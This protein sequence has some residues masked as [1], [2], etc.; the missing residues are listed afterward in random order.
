MALPQIYDEDIQAKMTRMQTRLETALGRA[1]SPGDIE[2]LIGNCFVYELQ[3]QCVAGNEGFRQN[4]VSFSTGAMLEYLGALV[5]V[6]RLAATASL[7]TLQF[8]LVDGHNAVQLPQGLRVQSI[9]GTV[10]FTT[11]AAVD[12]AIGVNT[13]TVEAIC[14][15]TGT[16]GNG[17]AAGLISVILDPQAFVTSVANTDTTNS[18]SDAETDDQLRSRIQIAPASFSVAGPTAAYIYW[19][20]TAD[21]TIVDVKCVTTNP[22][23]VTLYPLC[24]GGA[25]PSTEIQNAVLAIC[26]SNKVRPQNDTVLVSAPTVVNY[27]ISVNLT[28][29]TGAIDSDVLATVNAN[30]AAYQAAGQ[31]VLGR[32]VILSQIEALCSI[33]GQVYDV[34]I[35]SPTANIVA[36]DTTY[37]NC[38]G[39]T[40]NIIGSNNG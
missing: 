15:T 17:Y 7:C 32:D 10:I 8:N 25:L 6:T 38:T 5:G 23:E 28:T 37:V 36:D 35:A 19:A 27:A 31:N 12:I 33:A 21:P 34:A 39:I 3:L 24:T 30:L 13:V 1:L 11:T 14:Q 9:D 22:G 40:V 4:L 20:K 2:M 18:G 29:Y 26:S 16:S